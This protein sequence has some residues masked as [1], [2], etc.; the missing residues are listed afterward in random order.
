MADAAHQGKSGVINED[1]IGNDRT[2]APG[3]F[4]QARIILIPDG[5]QAPS[6]HHGIYSI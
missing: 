6:T 5:Q 1:K 4:P 2:F 3:C